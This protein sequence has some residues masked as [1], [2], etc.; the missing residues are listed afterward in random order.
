M[1]TLAA[2]ENALFVRMCITRNARC[3][4]A[5]HANQVNFCIMHPPHCDFIS[6]DEV[7]P[8]RMQLRC[9]SETC[10]SQISHGG[11]YVFFF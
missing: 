8:G 2:T 6:C 4:R 11:L 10:F 9:K 3:S 5:E 1:Q 7:G